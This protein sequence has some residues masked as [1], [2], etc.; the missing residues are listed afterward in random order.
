MQT[1]QMIQ[2]F[3]QITSFFFF[4]LGQLRLS[5]RGSSFQP[6]IRL[7]TSTTLEPVVARLGIDTKQDKPALLARYTNNNSGDTGSTHK[8]KLT[9]KS[10]P[11]SVKFL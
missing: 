3:E 2:A 7:R 8:G 4:F 5:D 10:C 1:T 9:N 11:V 6:V